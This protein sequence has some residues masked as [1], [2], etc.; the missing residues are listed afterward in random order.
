MKKLVVVGITIGLLC[1]P[2]FANGTK[3]KNSSSDVTIEFFCSKPEPAPVL[4]QMIT[5]FE[6]E[7]QGIKVVFTCPP[8]GETVLKTRL[9]AHDIP[10]VMNTFPA[11][12]WY[13]DLFDDGI[14]KDLTGQPVLSNVSEATLKLSSYHGKQFAVPETLSMYGL[15]CRK[16][17]FEKY[18]LA[19]PKSYEELIADCKVL[20]SHGIIPIA[21][22]DKT[23]G[24]VG[25]IMERLMGVLNN[26]ISQEFEQIASGKLDAEDA[27]TLQKF[28]NMMLELH[29]YSYENSL[30]VDYESTLA[31]V[32]NGKAAMD[33]NG[34]W[35]LSTL[36]ANNPD[37][38][39]AIEFIPFPNPYGKTNV[40][41]NIDTAISI[42]NI[43]KY[44][45]ASLKFVQFLM[46]PENA[47]SY[48]DFDKNP[49]VIQGVEYHVAPQAAISQYIA[50]GNMFLTP[51][52]FWP[53][54]LRDTL[55]APTQQLYLDGNV[56]TFCTN[57][58]K[59]I[60]EY[61]SK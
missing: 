29:K 58:G 6:E 48:T 56:Q 59:I 52:N 36:E 40:P 55:A 19:L 2:L 15:Y 12:K 11:E 31:D 33:I 42:S 44:P 20:Q 23:I 21:F 3:A 1:I 4:K 18:G 60:K 9:A 26:N 14:L 61:Y 57:F 27:P 43:T 37:I 5:K 34:S 10:D 45:D 16:D 39:S 30:T 51:C 8:D 25:Q 7:N 28:A 24:F 50:Q 32:A 41:I 22:P 54:G 47:Q 35:G 13:K 17:I 46:S 38:D 49:N 53:V